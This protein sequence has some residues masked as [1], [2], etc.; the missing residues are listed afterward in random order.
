MKNVFTRLSLAFLVFLFI[1]N[2]TVTAQAGIS[3]VSQTSAA[4]N[5][6]RSVTYGNGLFV[7]VAFSGTG[8][9]VMTSPDGI[10]WTIRTSAADY[11]WTSV[12]YGNGLFVA[13]CTIGA[14]GQQVMT[15]P[16]GITWTLRAVP[17]NLFWCAVTY[18]N[19]LFV[20]VAS[21]GTG[22]G[23]MT[24]PDGITWTIRTSAA[25]NQ[26]F[27]VTYGGGLFVAVAGSGTGNRVMTSPDGITWTIRISPA[28][29]TW[30]TVTYGV[31]LF[32]AL[33]N[34]GTGNRIMTSP[35]GITWTIRTSPANYSWSGIVYGGGLFVG[36]AATSVT[37]SVMTSPDGI[38]WTL[39]TAATT[40]GWNAIAYGGSTMV[41]VGQTGTGN[42]VMTSFGPATGLNFDGV[43]DRVILPTPVVANLNNFT[44]ES[45]VYSTSNSVYQTI[46]AEGYSGSL[47]PMFS[48][49]KT[50]GTNTGFEIVLR[51]NAAVGLVVGTTTGY[52][53]V[54]TWTHVAF[55]RTSATTA[56]LYINGINTDNFTFTDPGAIPVDETNIGVRQRN[57]SAFDGYFLGSIDEV[58]T[59]SRALPASEIQ[60]KLSCEISSTAQTGL[61]ALY[62]FNQGT[63]N[64]NNT[65]ITTATDAGGNGYTGTLSGFTLTGTTSNWSTGIATGS[66]PAPATGLDFDGT[67]DF[68][69]SADLGVTTT[70]KTFS[71]WVRLNSTSQ[72]GGGLVSLE[73]NDGVIFDAIVYNETGQGWGFGSDNG[74]RSVWSGVA[75]SSTATWVHIAATYSANSY[76]LYRNGVLILQTTAFGIATF[77]TNSRILVGK[78]HTGGGSAYLNAAIDEVQVWNRALCQS[79]VQNNMNCALTPSV[80]TGLVALYH[81]DQ[82]NVGSNNAGIT[83]LTDASANGYNATLTNFGLTGA[84]SNWSAG[85]TISGTCTSYIPAGLAATT[86]GATVTQTAAVNSSVGTFYQDNNCGVIAKVL[87]AGA[88]PVSGNV[89]SK[90]KIDATVQTYNSKPYVQRHYDIEPATNAANATAT[91]TLYFTQAEFTAY[92]AV[93]GALPALPTSAADATGIAN[94]R[95]TQYH[96]TG[97]APGNYSGTGLMI[98]PV[99]SDVIYNSSLSRWEVSFAVTG[100]SGFYVHTSSTA[101]PLP[102]TILSFTGKNNGN[103]K[104]LEWNTSNEINIKEFVLER[105]TDNSSYKDLATVTA[106]GAI[107]NAYSYNDTYNIDGTVYYRLRIIDNGGRITYSNTI[108]LSNRQRATIDI[109][110]NPVYDKLSV[111]VTDKKLLGTTAKIIDAAGK[112]VQTFIISNSFETVDMHALPAGLYLLQTVHGDSQKLIK[113]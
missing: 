32:V 48:I 96:G 105:S 92:N 1:S 84:T 103:N 79:E 23:V 42:R 41:A 34:T 104:L 40:N 8:N 81:F 24:S 68:A 63:V 6:W 66:C 72:T 46:Y 113:K 15:S 26:W 67:D 110:P 101:G 39:R 85:S 29:N 94:M 108:S 9:R 28:D 2:Q 82:G 100:F 54:N 10:T 99:N 22:N 47:N 73:R 55:V 17:A 44:F 60:N 86:G 43:N 62:H 71:A 16:D 11:S 53:P 97:T 21:N 56:K 109:F 13:T 59:W 14:G 65:A 102:L 70:D 95:I 35:D 91:V 88:V 78:R 4:D 20:A 27:A 112:T 7:A 76:K 80:Q 89:T 45:W 98:D 19:G 75:E 111:Q 49:T 51:N 52:I 87:P 5:N 36:V 93:R 57:V 90:V 83:S 18:G 37:N 25:N 31:G 77:P 58:R 12:T 106:K 107:V 74:T 38:T 69:V 50:S 30:Y 3:W 61:L 33:S 64:S